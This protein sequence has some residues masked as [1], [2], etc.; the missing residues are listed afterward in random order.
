MVIA[1]LGPLEN[2]P[3]ADE[4]NDAISKQTADILVGAAREGNRGLVATVVVC[5]SRF[6][7]S[8][9]ATATRSALSKGSSIPGQIMAI[10]GEY[11]F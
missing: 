4:T 2:T 1:E 5:A 11:K 7:S 6:V 10:D 8:L 3:E 9:D